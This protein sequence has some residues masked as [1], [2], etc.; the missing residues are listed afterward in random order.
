LTPDVGYAGSGAGAGAGVGI[1]AGVGV[2]AET[3][4]KCHHVVM[5][6]M[7]RVLPWNDSL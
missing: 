3:A 6:E 2:V 5:Y 1:G 7:V 4:E